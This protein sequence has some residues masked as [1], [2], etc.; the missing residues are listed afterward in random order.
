MAAQTLGTRTM[1][2]EELKKLMESKF[3]DV[4]RAVAA[5]AEGKRVQ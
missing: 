2:V 4:L 1:R 5:E 3:V